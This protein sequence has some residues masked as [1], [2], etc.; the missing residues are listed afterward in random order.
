MA[1]LRLVFMGTPDFAV[2]SLDALADAGHE[3]CRVYTQPPRRAGRG[4]APRPS[5]VQARAEARGIPVRTPES[6]KDAAAQAEFAALGADAAVVTA[7]GLILPAEILNAPRL[8]CFNVHA[9]LLPRWRGAAPIQRAIMAGD[10]TTGVTIMRMDE[11]LDTGAMLLAGE[12]PIGPATT[13]G[14]LH[15]ALAELGARLIVEALESVDAGRVQPIPQPADGVTYAKKLSRADGALDWRLPAEELERRVRALSPLPGAWFFHGGERIRVLEAAL[16][17]NEGEPGRVLDDRLTVACASGA[18]GLARV[19]RPGRKAMG[20]A[21][22][23]RGFDL[24]P[25]TVLEAPPK[26]GA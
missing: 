7:Y 1:G 9:S 17:D 2:A 6:L 24:P 20:A 3:I 18:L 10:T 23:L 4:Q 8:G 19:Q 25:G 15:D 13:G 16:L 5:A 26:E 14:T 11:G 22:F 21:D 12:V